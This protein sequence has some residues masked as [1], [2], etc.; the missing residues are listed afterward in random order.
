MRCCTSIPPWNAWWDPSGPRGGLLDL[1]AA[2]P[3]PQALRELGI[4]ELMRPRSPRLARTLPAQ[5]LTALEAQSVVVPGTAAFGRASSR[6]E[7]IGRGRRAKDA[8]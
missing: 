1:L 2:A 7:I 8:G 4:A 6:T 3:R 5:I